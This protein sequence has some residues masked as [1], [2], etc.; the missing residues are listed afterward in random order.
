MPPKKSTTPQTLNIKE[1][2]PQGMPVSCTW[3]IIAPPTTG[4]ST[5]IENFLYLNRHKYPCGRAFVGSPDAYKQAKKIFGDLY[6]TLGWDQDQYRSVCQRQ[7]EQGVEFEKDA[8]ERRLSLVV[9]DCSDDTNI[10]KTKQVISTFK[11]GSQHWQ[12]LAMFATQ[13]A[14]DFPPSVRASVSYVAIGRETD[15]VRRKTIYENF[16]GVCGT[17]DDFNKIMDTIAE[18]HRFLII[19][20]RAKT[21]NREDCLFYYETFRMDKDKKFKNWKFGAKEFRESGK[22]RVDPNYKENFAEF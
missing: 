5:L 16:G 22:L 21:N 8:V 12:T 18:G 15:A 17:F 3:I 10:Y 4:K 11:N 7:V 13:Y 1:F 20:K 2:D 9:D 14:M 6:V 19:S